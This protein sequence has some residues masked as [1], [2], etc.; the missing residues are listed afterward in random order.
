MEEE[1][2]GQL[3]ASL[4]SIQGCYVVDGGYIVDKNSLKKNPS[5]PGPVY[6]DAGCMKV[7]KA[8]K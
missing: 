3:A 2:T 8:S 7:T 4:Q 5:V 1:G 6:F